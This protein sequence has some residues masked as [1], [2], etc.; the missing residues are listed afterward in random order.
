M[1]AAYSLKETIERLSYLLISPSLGTK[2]SVLN[3]LNQ[4]TVHE[5]IHTNVPGGPKSDI[6]LIILSMNKNKIKFS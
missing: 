2:P 3:T 1:N 6:K 4:G 5:W